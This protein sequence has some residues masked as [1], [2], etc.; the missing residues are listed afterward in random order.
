MSWVRD[1]DIGWF[2]VVGKQQMGPVKLAGLV[3]LYTKGKAGGG[4]GEESLIWSDK[5]SGWEKLKNFAPLLQILQERRDAAPKPKP[6]PPAGPPRAPP[7]AAPDPRGSDRATKGVDKRGS[8]GAKADQ[9]HS[10][11]KA[12]LM[13][14]LPKRQ[15][16]RQ[17]VERG[18]LRD[19]P[20]RGFRKAGSTVQPSA[21]TDFFGGD[22]QHLLRRP[23]TANGIPAVVAVLME[24]LQSN[25]G[26]DGIQSEG[27]FRVPGDS[28]EMQ[29][30]R[31]Q[32]NGGADVRQLV[33]TC[34]NEHSVAGLLK[35]FFR[36]LREPLL[37]YAL[38]DDFIQCSAALGTCTDPTFHT[39]VG[40]LNQLLG[41]LPPGHRDLLLHLVMFLKEV[42]KHAATCKMTVGN[43]AA[44]FGP[45]LLRPQAEMLEHLA[46]TVHIV[47]LL[48]AMIAAPEATFGLAPPPE[49]PA[50]PSGMRAPPPPAAAPEP[51]A[52]AIAAGVERMY[53]AASE[54]QRPRR[55]PRR[56]P[57]S[58]HRSRATTRPSRRRRRR[59]ST[60]R[61]RRTRSSRRTPPPSRRRSSRRRRRRWRRRSAA[62]ALHPPLAGSP[63]PSPGAAAHAAMLHQGSTM[64][65]EDEPPPT[66]AAAASSVA[67]MSDLY[68]AEP[69]PGHELAAPPPEAYEPPSWYFVNA[70]NEQEG[71]VALGDLQEMLKQ[72]RLSLSTYVFSE[73]MENWTPASQVDAI[74]SGGAGFA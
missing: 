31:A 65:M 8:T 42:T 71:P 41:R 47:N 53:R 66:L 73:G 52:A 38:Y 35:M 34:Q 32:I 27:I 26:I 55:R 17:L 37:T 64:I 70:S 2:Y 5:M 28:S 43:C 46:D 18:I 12:F 68:T 44:V 48:A 69:E 67:S 56:R 72:S 14:W 62:A 29:G 60:R 49:P 50:P 61:S 58:T 39:R 23:D 30:M 22:L 3:E 20:A 25:G 74:S 9:K 63:P 11:V 59:P 51:A 33:A 13:G 16:P 40:G 4:I 6:P 1:P 10:G 15:D 36:E 19:D 21:P 24:R 45:N 57:R 54:L 7:A